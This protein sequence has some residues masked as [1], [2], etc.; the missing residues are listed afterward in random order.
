M[1][2]VACPLLHFNVPSIMAIVLAS[3]KHLELPISIKMSVTILQIVY[4]CM[5]VLSPNLS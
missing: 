2:Q 3:F 5:T 1:Y 4:V